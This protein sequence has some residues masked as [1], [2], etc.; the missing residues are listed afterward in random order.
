MSFVPHHQRKAVDLALLLLAVATFGG[1]TSC[2]EEFDFG[3]PPDFDPETH[4]E[5]L[6]VL[7][8]EFSFPEDATVMNG[9]HFREL[10]PLGCTFEVTRPYWLQTTEV[11]R[12]QI[13]PLRDQLLTP[14][15]PR[16]PVDGDPLVAVEL[17]L[18]VDMIL[19]MNWR[20]EQDSFEPCYDIAAHCD[21]CTV[22]EGTHPTMGGQEY[23]CCDTLPPT[24]P[25]CTGYRFPREIEY[26]HAAAMGGGNTSIWKDPVCPPTEPDS[27]IENQ[28]HFDCSRYGYFQI[29]DSRSTL[30]G[31]SVSLPYQVGT[32]Y[33][34]NQ[35]GFYGFVDNVS[36][37][38]GDW[39]GLIGLCAAQPGTHIVDPPRSLDFQSLV[40]TG[41]SWMPNLTIMD[42]GAYDVGDLFYMNGFRMARDASPEDVENAIRDGLAVGIDRPYW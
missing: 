22:I 15:S 10:G 35:W 30:P 1:V 26:I 18:P 7:P 11:Y 14:S 3:F 6:L 12:G 8:G 28:F 34:G 16:V 9:I 41:N 40:Y 24:I 33:P 2:R 23:P 36:E 25:G 39:A 5:F 17:M 20:S 31:E 4:P 13:A 21:V 42:L 29:M 27:G 38:L 19:F 37:P 32:R